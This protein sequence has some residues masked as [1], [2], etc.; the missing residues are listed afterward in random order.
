MV[1]FRDI[2]CN[3]VNNYSIIFSVIIRT[4]LRQEPVD[5]IPIEKTGKLFQDFEVIFSSIVRTKLT[6]LS[7]D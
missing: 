2:K 7:P 3:A 1:M 4:T 6:V 5:V